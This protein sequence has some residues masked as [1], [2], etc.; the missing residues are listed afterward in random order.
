MNIPVYLD[1][2][3]TTR[4]DRRVIE[5]MIPLMDEVYGNASSTQHEFGWR[6]GA[7]VDQARAR[8]A[9]LVGALPEEIVFTSGATESV[10]L[11]LKGAV[12]G[13]G[14]QGGRIITAQ[15]EHRAVLDACTRLQG[16][17]YEVF[18]VPVDR[19]GVVDPDEIAR[20]MTP[21]TL[22]VSVM[23]AN[24]EIG[25]LAPVAAIGALCAARG[26]L[27]H[28]DATQAAG[29]VP[30]DMHAMQADLLSFSAHKIYGPKGVGALAVRARHP[31]I[32]LIPLFDGGGHERGIRS[33]TLNVPGIAGFGVAA[34]IAADVMGGESAKIAALRDRLVAGL[35]ENIEGVVVNGHPSLRLPHNANLLFPG[36]GAD[37]VMM[38]MKDI[39]VSSGSACSSASPEPSHV[40]AAIGLGREEIL[41]SLRFGLGRF[42][43]EEEI[44]YAIRRVS[45]TVRA[46]S[47][48]VTHEV[49]V[50]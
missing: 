16:E 40:L 14:K 12:R 22:L 17:G 20:A 36:A 43:T 19:Y 3:A 35:Q 10:N 28:T 47:R 15:T 24:N 44:D 41:S 46:V 32:R 8:V 26:V 31:A 27:F 18:R 21:G 34:A 9:N 38:A 42:T 33:G 29:K 30:V 13:L 4:V 39:A 23:A 6:A 48:R 45:E 7:A 2:H 25:T 50:H 37:R 5:A 49:H 11:A 1:N